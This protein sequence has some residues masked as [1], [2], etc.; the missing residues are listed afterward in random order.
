MV[1]L[2]RSVGI[3]VLAVAAV[4]GAGMLSAWDV[5]LLGLLI[6]AAAGLVGVIAEGPL[7][8]RMAVCGA[9][10]CVAT[11]QQHQIAALAAI[12]LAFL[13]VWA[14]A[15]FRRSLGEIARGRRT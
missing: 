10:M 15:D 12:P 9:L 6:V 2:T 14:G 4:F 5:A 8:L 3:Q 1:T 7:G 11:L 13:G